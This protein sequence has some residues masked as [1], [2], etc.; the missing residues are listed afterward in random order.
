M[1]LNDQGINSWKMNFLSA[2]GMALIT[3]RLCIR[4][5]YYTTGKFTTA[6]IKIPYIPFYVFVTFCCAVIVIEFL[7]LIV[8]DLISFNRDDNLYKEDADGV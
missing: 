7:I 2:V 6:V 8:K 1:N 3:W 4:V 5:A